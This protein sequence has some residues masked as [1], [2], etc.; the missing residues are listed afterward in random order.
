MLTKSKLLAFLKSHN[1]IKV[2]IFLKEAGCGRNYLTQ[3]EINEISEPKAKKI[4]EVMEKYGYK[5]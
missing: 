5:Q 1:A 2:S 3:L 4:L